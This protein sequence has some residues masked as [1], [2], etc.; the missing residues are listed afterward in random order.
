LDLDAIEPFAGR[1]ITSVELAGHRVTLDSVIR[2]ELRSLVGEPL[3]PQTVAADVQRLENLSIFAEIGVTAQPDGDG[4]RLTVQLKEMPE[5]IPWVGFSY[6][7]QDGFSGGPKVS[8]LNLTGRAISLSAKA[9]FGGANQYTAR[10]VWPWIAG[11]HLSL[12]VYGARITRADTLNGFQET[13]Y[14][15]TPAVGTY[16][17]EHGRLTGKFSL[18]RMESD[19]P[20]TTLDSDLQ[21]VLPR[22]G[23][24]VGWDTRDS[25]RFP[26][27]GWWNELELWRTGLGGDGDFWSMNLD[28]RRYVPI[29]KRQRMLVSGL[30]SVQSGTVGEDIP[31][32]LTYYLGGANTIR[33]YSID[34]LGPAL[35]GKNQ[36]LG[37]VE[38][39][40]NV[41]PLR[42]W[43]IWKFALSMGLD[44]AVFTDGG[45]AWSDSKDLAAHRVRG[46][47]GAGLRLLVPG[48][49]MVRLDVGWSEAGGF[50]F[51][52][53][54][55][56]KP[57]AQRQRLR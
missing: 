8:A 33:G 4:V 18:F 47:L 42:R 40:V 5:Y 34:S 21:D 1:R 20:G 28:L 19:T 43:D 53:A 44:V 31:E 45:I 25:W 52:F 10:F 48:S 24:S 30:A 46:G 41:V 3:E 32:Y 54:S 36:L 35:H 51:H 2:R 26:S 7:E 27:R 16:L 22:L 23:V 15:F 39:S 17:G 38:Y 12:D 11:D 49:E 37:T 50:Q 14:E 6:T 57:V 56:S 55:G 9:Y 13:S 29:T